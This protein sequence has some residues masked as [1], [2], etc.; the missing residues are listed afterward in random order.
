MLKLHTRLPERW[1]EEPFIVRVRTGPAPKVPSD[2]SDAML[3]KDS[4]NSTASRLFLP[5]Q[6]RTSALDRSRPESLRLPEAFEYLADGDI[7]RVSPTHGELWVMYRRDSRFNSMLLTERCNSFCVMCSQPP[8]AVDDSYLVDAFL[9]AIPLIS[10]DTPE[11]G[12]T[13]GEPTLLG[14]RLLDLIATCRDEL[15]QTALHMLSNGRLFQ[16]LPLCQDLAAI[17]HPDFMIGIPLYSDLAHKHDFVVQ[18]RGAFDQTIRGFMNLQRCGLRTELRIVLHRATV[19]RLPQLAQFISRNLPF[20]EHVALMGL[21]MMGFVRM[22]LD[23]LWI[24]SVDYQPQLAE[25]V[26][27][28][29]HHGMNVSIYNHQLCVLDRALWP[30][31]RMSISDWK[32]EYLDDCATCAVREDCGG[33]FSSSSL[34][35]SDHIRA[36]RPDEIT[37]PIDSSCD[38]LT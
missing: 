2:S 13:G 35:R 18:A 10:P 9:E 17:Q 20:I 25:A 11:L 4:G 16:Y 36:L 24:D 19:D 3:C 15:P 7:V 21:E 8:K 29:S 1:D 22:N 27:T 33:F 34:R 38:L 28:L 26:Q 5:A 12:I 14:K 32:N 31:A 23:A 37:A 30:F 6:D